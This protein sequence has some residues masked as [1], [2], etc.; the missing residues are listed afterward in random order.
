MDRI[1]F[2]SAEALKKRN[3]NTKSELYNI[4]DVKMKLKQRMDNLP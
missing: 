3:A 1:A 2:E 4:Y